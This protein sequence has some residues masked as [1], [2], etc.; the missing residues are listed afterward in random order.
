ML[1][2]QVDLAVVKVDRL[3]KLLIRVEIMMEMVE[4]E[5]QMDQRLEEQMVV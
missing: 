3:V 4:Q 5:D 2:K 1:T